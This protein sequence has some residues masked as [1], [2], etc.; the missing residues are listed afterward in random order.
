MGLENLKLQANEKKNDSVSFSSSLGRPITS[1]NQAKEELYFLNNNFDPREEIKKNNNSFFGFLHTKEEDKKEAIYIPNEA[2]NHILLCGIT[3]S[4]K[5]ILAGNKSYE[6]LQDKKQ[7]LI[8]IDVKQESF[9]P[10]IIKEELKK[11]NRED[12]L[13][14]ISYPNNY[15]YD[16]INKDDK[17]YQVHEKL[18]E[19]LEISK[20]L[21]EGVGY[22]K[23]I[24]RMT[25]LSVINV[26]Y[27][28]FKEL[29]LDNILATLKYL[30]MDFE[31]IKKYYQ[32]QS[33]SKPNMF[34]LNEANNLFFKKD[35]LDSLEFTDENIEG[36]K[37]LYIKLFELV[38]NANIFH[39]HTIDEA[40]YNGKV[41]YIKGDMLSQSSLRLLKM[42]FVDISQRARMKKANC[43]VIADEISFYATENLAGALSTMA[44]FGVRYI[45]QLQDLSQIQN[46]NLRAAIL[47]NC[48]VKLFYKISDSMTLDYVEKLGG[49]ELVTQYGQSGADTVITQ[50]LE[51]LLNTTRIRAMWFKQNAILIAEYLNTA[52]FINTCF[53]PV[54]NEFDW[55][56][57]NN[58]SFHKPLI[59]LEKKYNIASK[60]LNDN[61]Q[62]EDF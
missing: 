11:Q 17:P 7:G 5:G 27:N 6:V 56:S 40:L 34:I 16:S 61:K 52:I 48:S 31:N 50:S 33:K 25:L 15:G 19:G 49:E 35:L 4:G 8:Y 54:L 47:T 60:G 37:S 3:R 26:A 58:S 38:N 28:Q 24:E 36:L 62:D 12:D 41:L 21:D 14:V 18:C 55:S 29:S 59:S 39:K 20:S 46:E 2:I 53:I 1:I 9:T 22:Y 51:P 44:G 42:L 32:E 23:G 30:K 57:Y 13:I 45:L 43:T 10:Q